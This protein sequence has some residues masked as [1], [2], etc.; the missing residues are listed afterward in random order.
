MPFVLSLTPAWTLPL[1]SAPAWLLRSAPL[2]M[3]QEPCLCWLS[4]IQSP[5][6]PC[7]APEE[8]GTF[9]VGW[10]SFPGSTRRLWSRRCCRSLEPGVPAE[11]GAAQGGCAGL[12]WPCPTS[13]AAPGSTELPFQMC[14][15]LPAGWTGHRKDFVP[16]QVLAQ[17]PC[18]RMGLEFCIPPEVPAQF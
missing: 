5:S 2:S 17:A 16:S 4:T 6:S 11:C 1:P 10:P 15:E 7:T 13:S 9:P 14:L 3:V 18:R 12:T 8:P